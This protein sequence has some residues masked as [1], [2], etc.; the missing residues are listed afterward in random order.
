MK[1]IFKSLYNFFLK[2]RI[3]YWKE[4]FNRAKT[5]FVEVKDDIK[6]SSS[7]KINLYKTLFSRKDLIYILIG[8]LASLSLIFIEEFFF[9]GMLVL[10]VISF[11][12]FYFKEKNINT[13]AIKCLKILVGMYIFRFAYILFN[14]I[15]DTTGAIQ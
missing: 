2:E 8:F 6:V 4:D 10:I 12:F 11:L 15:R 9:I 14:I 13:S 3:K 1:K 7:R 5:V